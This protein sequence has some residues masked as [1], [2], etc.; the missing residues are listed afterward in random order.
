[1]E[2]EREKDRGGKRNKISGIRATEEWRTGGAS[3]R[4]GEEGGGDIGG[5]E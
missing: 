2:I 4:Q 3:E 5:G 1:M